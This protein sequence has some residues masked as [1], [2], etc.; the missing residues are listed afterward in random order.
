VYGV[1]QGTGS[2]RLGHIGFKVQH[3]QI[4]AL[5]L[6]TEDP[7]ARRLAEQITANYP[8]IEIFSRFDDLM[9]KFPPVD[10]QELLRDLGDDS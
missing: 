5:L 4:D 7:W 6:P 10:V 2:V 9:E 1:I 8:G 3:A